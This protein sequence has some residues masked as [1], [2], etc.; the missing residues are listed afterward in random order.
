M[1]QKI[2]MKVKMNCQKCQTKAL[3]VVAEANGVNFVG[4]EGA[5]KDKVVVIGDGIDAVK[6]ATS[7]RKKVGQTDIISVGDVKKN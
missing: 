3:T 2:V 6:L 1:T 7:L 4:L 5:E